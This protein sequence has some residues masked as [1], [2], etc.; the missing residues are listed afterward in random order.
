M[1][2]EV[3]TGM[4]G[5]WPTEVPRLLPDAVRNLARRIVTHE[6]FITN[7]REGLD[8]SFAMPLSLMAAEKKVPE[9]YQMSIGAVYEEF[10]KAAQRSINGYP[11][12]MSCQFVHKDD[13]P[14]LLENVEQM[15]A[16]IA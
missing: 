13:L 2:E 7:Q 6:V 12:F 5:Q 16:A 3:T 8:L 15:R 9:S 11:M 4:E 1:P 10:S 14:L